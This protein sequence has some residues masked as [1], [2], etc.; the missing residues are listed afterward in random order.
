MGVQSTS[1]LP[2]KI[3]T[4]CFKLHCTIVQYTLP[5]V[6]VERRSM[7][8]IDVRHLLEEDCNFIEVEDNPC[9]KTFH[10]V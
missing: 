5:M 2:V 9:V 3:P 6:S 7:G 10:V 1:Q 4:W 8:A